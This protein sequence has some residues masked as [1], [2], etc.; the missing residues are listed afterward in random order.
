[1]AKKIEKWVDK[2][3]EFFVRL[4]CKDLLKSLVKNYM[5]NFGRKFLFGK[6]RNNI[7]WKSWVEKMGERNK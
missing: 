7:V 3:C 6:R 4:E 5:E 1:M 2:L